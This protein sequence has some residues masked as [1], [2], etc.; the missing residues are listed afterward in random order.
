[1]HSVDSKQDNAPGRNSSSLLPN[2]TTLSRF[3]R[4]VQVEWVVQLLLKIIKP[5]HQVLHLGARR[6]EPLGQVA[7]GRLQLQRA[8]AV[9]V[10]ATPCPL[11]LA[12]PI[13]IVAGG[14]P[15]A[16]PGAIV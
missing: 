1:M 12:A 5:F 4:V 7:V 15:R 11:L 2:W 9:L 6:L 3:R 14:R 16:T 8:L 10:V 13:A